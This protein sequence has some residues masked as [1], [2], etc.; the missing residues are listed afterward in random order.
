MNL[1]S[2]ELDC[3]S[4]AWHPRHWIGARFFKIL[5]EDP[6]VSR[7]ND[8]HTA[9][10]QTLASK[11]ATDLLLRHAPGHLLV[12]LPQRTRAPR[13]QR[14]PAPTQSFVEL[15]LLVKVKSISSEVLVLK[16]THAKLLVGHD[17]TRGSNL[18]D[19]SN[20]RYWLD[21]RQRGSQFIHHL[22]NAQR[23]LAAEVS[24]R[25]ADDE[26]HGACFRPQSSSSNG[27]TSHRSIH[28][29]LQHYV[30]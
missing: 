25:S 12:N 5:V 1:G 21:P 13:R 20:K 9:E 28:H 7:P 4:Q 16:L 22:H 10:C 19:D 6:L 11:I 14:D 8:Q 30:A 18:L 15:Q 24:A 2:N 29:R 26:N 3:C 23:F 17:L 27:V